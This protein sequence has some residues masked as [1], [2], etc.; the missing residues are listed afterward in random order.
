MR[1]APTCEP[2]SQQRVQTPTHQTNGHYSA[3]NLL[4][5]VLLL[6]SRLLGY[7]WNAHA[8]H[9]AVVVARPRR[10][11]QADGGWRG[12][13]RRRPGSCRNVLRRG[14]RGD[15]CFSGKECVRDR[16][17]V[18]QQHRG[19]DP[20]LYLPPSRASGCALLEMQHAHK[21][22]Q[23]SAKAKT[24]SADCLAQWICCISNV[25]ASVPSLFVLMACAM[26]GCT[27]PYNG[28]GVRV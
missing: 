5:R 28:C 4:A 2:S 18:G 20:G 26:C 11:R 15:L 25:R 12:R 3:S 14:S 23:Q 22:Q 9:V 10:F 16:F 8:V 13:R 24:V 19:V 7:I 27:A 21:A 6:P 17:P 1:S